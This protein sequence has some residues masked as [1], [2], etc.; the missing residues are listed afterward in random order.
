MMMQI[1]AAHFCAGL[2]MDE[3][4]T[5]AAPILR[6]MIGWSSKRV[7]EYCMRNGWTM[8]I[9]PEFNSPLRALMDREKNLLND[10]DDDRDQDR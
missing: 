10:L 4:V 3:K 5:E 8:E 2:V 1:T 7:I 6:Y 9:V